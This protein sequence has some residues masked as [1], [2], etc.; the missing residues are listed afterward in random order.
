M[1]AT[2]DSGKESSTHWYNRT[3][4]RRTMIFSVL[5]PAIVGVISFLILAQYSAL[6]DE[7]NAAQAISLELS[8]WEQPYN[9]FM[10]QFNQ[11]SGGSVF[12]PIYPG[13]GAYYL[14]SKE[15]YK[16]K[17]RLENNLS[18][19]YINLQKAETDRQEFFV[20]YTNK[21]L[22]PATNLLLSNGIAKDIG[23][24]LKVLPD[25]KEQLNVQINEKFLWFF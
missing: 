16:F 4:F 25:V 10:N 8:Q 2:K 9:E 21:A 6:Q 7:R 19:C 13:N 24:C 23:N 5:I 17:P 22:D 18:Y 11:S 3:E 14:Y 12:E 20:L 15:I 1:K